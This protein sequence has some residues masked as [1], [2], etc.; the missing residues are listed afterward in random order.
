MKGLPFVTSFSPSATTSTGQVCFNVINIPNTPSTA[1]VQ[2]YFTQ[3]YYTFTK[4]DMV[5]I[6]IDLHG[7][8]SDTYNLAT[9]NSGMIGHCIFSF[10]I[11]GIDDFKHAH[12]VDRIDVTS[13]RM[14]IGKLE[15]TNKIS[16]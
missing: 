13:N 5:N 1:W 15:N 3:Q 16:M 8:L 9:S 2:N 11:Y 12:S 6:T 10:N 4:Q 7:V 14:N